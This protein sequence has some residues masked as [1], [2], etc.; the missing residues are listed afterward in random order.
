MA[1]PS[2]GVHMHVLGASE[3]RAEPRNNDCPS[4][5]Q[6]RLARHPCPDPYTRLAA[7]AYAALIRN[8]S[9]AGR[10]YG[11]AA[12][13]FGY[14]RGEDT[15]VAA[16]SVPVAGGGVARLLRLLARRFDW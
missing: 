1:L 6:A 10:L 4:T 8:A 5:T 16:G 2:S 7:A 13:A 9:E 3:L 15:R 14:V 12:R 11:H